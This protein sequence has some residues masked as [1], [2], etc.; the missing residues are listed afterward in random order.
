MEVPWYFDTFFP[1]GFENGESKQ[2][3]RD[4]K[5]DVQLDSF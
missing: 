1:G 3:K 4:D 5:N 2:G